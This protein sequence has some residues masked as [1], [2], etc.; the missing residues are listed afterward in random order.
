MM[1]GIPI[2]YGGDKGGEGS[3]IITGIIRQPATWGESLEHSTFHTKIN[4]VGPHY[5]NFKI[6]N[7]GEN[8]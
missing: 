5:L 2:K 3:V 6:N 7:L 1:W 4:S 8:F